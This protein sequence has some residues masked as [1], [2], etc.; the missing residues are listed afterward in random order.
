MLEA[1]DS[2][3]PDI[4]DSIAHAKTNPIEVGSQA[5]EF[6][7]PQGFTMA[8]PELT[9]TPFEGFLADYVLTVEY[10]STYDGLPDVLSHALYRTHDLWYL[11]MRLNGASTRADFRGP[12]LKVFDPVA[13]GAGVLDALKA[14]KKRVDR[15]AVIATEDLTLRPVYG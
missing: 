1:Y 11:L 5:G 14:A 13:V 15:S 2:A 10:G 8:D 3:K 6:V 4:R 9:L 7:D 12:T